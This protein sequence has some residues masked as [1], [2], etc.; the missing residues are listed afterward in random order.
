MNTT[1]FR[2]CVADNIFRCDNST[3]LPTSLYVGL[4]KTEPTVAGSNVTEPDSSAGYA[5]VKLDGLS[6]AENGEVTN[7]A[8]I[9]FPESTADWGVI[10]H[11]GIFD[12]ASDGN[13]LM[14]GSLSKSRTVESETVMT[15]SQNT[16]SL[17]VLDPS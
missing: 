5:R 16:L 14:F 12:A 7:A 13:L 1:Y 10:T 6:E 15:I 8:A 2:N 9:S 3:P 11:Y 17:S 4:S